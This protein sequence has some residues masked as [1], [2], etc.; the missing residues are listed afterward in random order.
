MSN[1]GGWSIGQEFYNF[2]SQNLEEG[3]TIV[4]FGSGKGT[5]ELTKK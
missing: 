4:E 3:K 2:L 1:L 5:I